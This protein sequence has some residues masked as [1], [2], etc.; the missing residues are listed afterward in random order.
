[1]QTFLDSAHLAQE[2]SELLHWIRWGRRSIFYLLPDGDAAVAKRFLLWA[3]HASSNPMP[4]VINVD[5]LS[6]SN[7]DRLVQR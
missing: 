1:M 7:T 3:I 2:K 6:R 5:K 4:R